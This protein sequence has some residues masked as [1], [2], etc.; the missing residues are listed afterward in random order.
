MPRTNRTRYTILGVLTHGAMSG[1]DV[2]SFIER[3]IG[4]FWRESYGQIYP[5]LK[6]LE[7][8]GLVDRERREGSGRPDRNV[9][10]ITRRGSE[11]L[12]EWL[13]LPAEPEIPRHELL[14][15][16]FFGAQVDPE[17]N[18]RHIARYRAQ[19]AEA[20]VMLRST[21]ERLIVSR[22]DAADLPFWLLGIRLGV[23]VNEGVVD[24]CAEAEAVLRGATTAE[25]L[26]VT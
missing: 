18:L 22:P 12:R 13:V 19:A 8:E 14:L 25:D 24:W 26:F 20:L 23:M 3:S 11:T 17:D 6:A 16:L 21:S 5:T 9:Y 1:Y 15:K 2:K 4:N 7:A 10:S